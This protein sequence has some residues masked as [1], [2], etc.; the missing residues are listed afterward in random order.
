MKSGWTSTLVRGV[1]IALL[2]LGVI[3]FGHDVFSSFHSEEYVAENGTNGITQG[4]HTS[5]RTLGTGI[6]GVAL[7]ILSLWW[8]RGDKKS[9]DP[10]I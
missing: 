7:I 3:L 1:G 2:L 5:F 9:S 4:F 8:P 10:N 6:G